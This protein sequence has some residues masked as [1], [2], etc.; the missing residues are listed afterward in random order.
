[1]TC[2]FH[3]NSGQIPARMSNFSMEYYNSEQYNAFFVK[4]SKMEKQNDYKMEFLQNELSTMTSIISQLQ[5]DIEK[6]KSKNCPKSDQNEVVFH[7]QVR[8]AVDEYI[9]FNGDQIRMA[10]YALE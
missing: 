1:M 7:E 5:R 9:N 10:D 4:S 8:E 3:P 2:I 6:M